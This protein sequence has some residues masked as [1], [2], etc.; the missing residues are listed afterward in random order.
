MSFEAKL[1]L[2]GPDDRLY[3]LAQPVREGAWGLL[4]LAGRADQE[5]AE[6]W[7]GEVLLGV[8]AGQA[9][10]GDHG[11]ARHRPVRRLV[12]QGFPGLLAFAVQLGMR[13]G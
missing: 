9:L 2:Q 8:L 12:L 4:V 10:T 3:P 11:G 1:V 6:V 5:Q 13:P 7:A